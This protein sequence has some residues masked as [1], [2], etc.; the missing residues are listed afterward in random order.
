M[1]GSFTFSPPD[2]VL[3]LYN[4]TTKD[5]VTTYDLNYTDPAGIHLQIKQGDFITSDDYVYKKAVTFISDEQAQ[6][7]LKDR[8]VYFL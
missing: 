6:E 2:E 8:F 4:P 7:W 5:Y 3:C 1:W